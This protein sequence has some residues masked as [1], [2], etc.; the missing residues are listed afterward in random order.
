MNKPRLIVNNSKNE[1]EYL[2]NIQNIFDRDDDGGHSHKKFGGAVKPRTLRAT[3]STGFSI[4][5][6]F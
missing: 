1:I 5:N 2:E 4:L 6:I 3:N